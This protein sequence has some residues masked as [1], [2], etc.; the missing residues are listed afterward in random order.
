MISTRSNS[1]SLILI[2]LD[3]NNLNLDLLFS[4]LLTGTTA[5]ILFNASHSALEYNW[6]TYFLDICFS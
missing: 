6:L 3:N 2:F 4:N 1:A 5:N